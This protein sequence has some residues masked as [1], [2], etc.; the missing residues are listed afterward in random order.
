MN[1]PFVSILIVTYNQENFVVEALESAL[2][3]SYSNYE[4]VV[5]D[6][7]STDRTPEILK[8]YGL[9]YPDKLRIILNKY[10]KGVT[11]NHNIA[12]LNASGDLLCVMGGDDIL[13]PNK[14]DKQV[15]FMKSNPECIISF[16]DLEVFDSVSSRILHLFSSQNIP[17]NGTVIHS[18]L[19]G[20]FNG[21]CSTMWRRRDDVIFDE[22]IRRASDWLFWIEI[23]ANGGRILYINDVLAS[24]RRHD[25][26]VSSITSAR[27]AFIEHLR[28]LSI[29]LMKYPNLSL[30][31][32]LS[33]GRYLLFESV[34]LMRRLILNF[35][36][37]VRNFWSCRF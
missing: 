26:N 33:L 28:T 21:A 14:L 25:Q 9:K 24:Y 3:Q 29:V 13:L 23:L 5:S 22:R 7:G 12:L 8:R 4:I 2:N 36:G 15:S 32:I 37:N 34:F 11:A 27:A 30:F 17:R 6:D 10:N 18:I 1:D 35:F 16:H 20:T 31:V 19:Y